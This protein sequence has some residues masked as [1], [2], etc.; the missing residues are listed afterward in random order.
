MN[1]CLTMYKAHQGP[2]TISDVFVG[3]SLPKVDLNGYYVDSIMVIL[4]VCLF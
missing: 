3:R 2:I 1:I 4:I